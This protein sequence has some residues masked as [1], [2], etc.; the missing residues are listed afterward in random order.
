MLLEVSLSL[1]P[2]EAADIDSYH[3]YIENETKHP[4]SSISMYKLLHRSI[5]ARQRNIKVNLKLLVAINEP[6][7]EFSSPHFDYPNV[8]DKQEVLIIGSGP[9]GLFAALRLIEL[10]LKPIIFERGKSVKERRK[11]IVA[12]TTNKIVDTDSNYCFGEGGAGTFSDGKLYTRSKKRGDVSKILNVLNFHGASEDILIDAQPHIG[13]NKLPGVVENIRQTIINSG[14]EIH[15]NSRISKIVTNNKKISALEITN[16]L[17]GNKHTVNTNK[18]IL[19]TGH[20][21]HDIYNTLHES[22]IKMEAKPFAMGVRV[23]HPQE[24]IDTIQ[25]QRKTRGSYLPAASYKAATQV[26]GRGVYSFCMCP[27]GFIVPAATGSQEVVVNG[28]SPASRNSK[29]AN[30]GIVVEIRLE[31]LKKYS[32]FGALAGLK[33]QQEIEQLAYINGGSNLAAPAQRLH[34]FVNGRISP[35]LPECSYKPGVLSAPLHFVLPEMVGKQA[36]AARYQSIRK[37][38]E[39]LLNKRSNS[40]GRRIKNFFSN[41]NTPQLGNNATRRN[42]RLISCR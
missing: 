23:E 14:G 29:F 41:K 5:D 10:N 7:P 31:D 19:A 37:K 1:S 11:N 26:N 9:A 6:A 18:V 42:R 34:D 30:S 27:G 17:N 25:Y 32:N 24:I 20:S 28:M 22:K 38:N 21:A 36:F 16:T 8:A 12:I 39:I 4:A 13:T 2:E 40:F 35:N 3:K 33:F 15:F